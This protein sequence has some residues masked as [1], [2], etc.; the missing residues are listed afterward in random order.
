YL[1]TLKKYVRN[2]AHPEGSIAEGYL[3]DECVTFLAR[4]L[5]EV[6]SRTNRPV[7]YLDDTPIGN[8][9]RFALSTEQKKLLHDY[10]LF[11]DNDVDT[12]VEQHKATLS[13]LHPKMNNRQR[14]LKHKKEFADWF[15][16]H[17]MLLSRAQV[18]F[19]EGLDVLAEGP[20]TTARRF[21]GYTTRGYNF[22]TFNKECGAKTQNSGVAVESTTPFFRNAA[23][24][25]PNNDTELTYYGRLKDIIELTYRLGRKFVLFDCDWFDVVSRSGRGVKVDA[26]GFTLVNFNHRIPTQEQEPFVLAS[27]VR[28]I[29]YS[30]DPT[31]LD[32]HVVVR[33]KPRDVFDMGEG[34]AGQLLDNDPF[35]RDF[36]QG[37]VVDD[38]IAFLEMM[39]GE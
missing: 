7:R 33:N 28:Q 32:W 37:N 25:N 1:Y 13:L 35:G 15:R 19:A 39:V 14:Q 12:Y 26:L 22:K 31:E 30:Q 34:N 9:A 8:A 36:E 24:Q 16:E 5:K 3:A 10:I 17:I 6:E 11:N 20:F 21:R 23:D 27:Q 4:Y 29:F 38:K 2:K 18:P